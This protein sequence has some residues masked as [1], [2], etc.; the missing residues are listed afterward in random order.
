MQRAI[1]QVRAEQLDRER[2]SP[3]VHHGGN[4]AASSSGPVD[5][6]TTWVPGSPTPPVDCRYRQQQQQ[7]Q[8]DTRDRTSASLPGHHSQH[9][10]SS[11]PWLQS[12]VAGL[13]G[14]DDDGDSHRTNVRR[15]EVDQHLLGETTARLSTQ[16][17][18]GKRTQNTSGN[19]AI[20]GLRRAPWGDASDAPHDPA[21]IGRAVEAA[22]APST[23]LRR[24][25]GGSAWSTKE[26]SKAAER[27]AERDR[28]Q[29]IQA[30]TE[31][32][33]LAAAARDAAYHAV[34]RGERHSDRAELHNQRVETTG[35]CTINRPLITMHD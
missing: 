6:D 12:S 24:S 18:A 34:A 31:A 2:L 11:K 35:A 30:E 20:N 1:Q 17:S 19:L 8:I 25:G 9:R 4:T 14:G 16:V 29:R 10:G 32:L 28:Q 15:G 22:S 23:P 13:L 5:A 21:T 7:H 33:R 27:S 26:R 3:A